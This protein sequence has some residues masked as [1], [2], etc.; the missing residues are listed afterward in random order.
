MGTLACIWWESYTEALRLS[1]AKEVDSP[2]KES[3]LR[4][5]L[6]NINTSKIEH[7]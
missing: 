6:Q 4:S 3:R 2:H 7:L 1:T 5:S